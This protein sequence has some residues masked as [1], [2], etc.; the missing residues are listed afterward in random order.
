LNVLPSLYN[1]FIRLLIKQEI[2]AE[3]YANIAYM[4]ANIKKSELKFFPCDYILRGVDGVFGNKTRNSVIGYQNSKGLTADG[5][6][7]PITWQTL[8]S[9]VVGKGSSSTTIIN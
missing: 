4:T 6:L 8:M 7:G 9:D 1:W 5:I 3:M 2:T